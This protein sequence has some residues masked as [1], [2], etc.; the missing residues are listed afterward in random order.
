MGSFREEETVDSRY[1]SVLRH[2]V[3]RT[4]RDSDDIKP[5]EI[6]STT[7]PSKACIDEMYITL[8]V[9]EIATH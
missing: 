3:A 4:Q 5:G 8:S 2:F 7:S 1:V 6:T 9:V